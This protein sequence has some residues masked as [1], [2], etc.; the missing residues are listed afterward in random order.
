MEDEDI[1]N[2]SCSSANSQ[3]LQNP[4]LDESL[5]I[6]GIY[7]P[8]QENPPVEISNPLI[9]VSPVEVHVQQPD[10]ASFNSTIDLMGEEDSGVQASSDFDQDNA[11]SEYVE[12]N[13][14]FE[15]DI[16]GRL[17]Y[18][19]PNAD[20]EPYVPPTLIPAYFPGPPSI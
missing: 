10:H 18:E 1:L 8:H 11:P 13:P 15:Y 12:S 5:E 14:S 20:E 6:V 7:T 16:E 3:D 9:E 17:N 4:V 19:V 2:S